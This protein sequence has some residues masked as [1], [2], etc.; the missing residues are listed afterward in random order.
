MTITLD[1]P[2]DL[3]SELT[4]EAAHLGLS[5]GKYVLRVL[6]TGRTTPALPKTGAELVAYWQKEGLIGTRPD[7]KDSTQH[8]RA[9]RAEAE[10]RSQE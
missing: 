2:P 9:V 5:L 7:I 8:A 3:E 6:A 10:R 4:A 1:L